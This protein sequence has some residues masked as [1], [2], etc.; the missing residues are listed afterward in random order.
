MA[1]RFPP[2]TDADIQGAVIKALQRAGWDVVRAID[3]FPEGT[4]DLP[5]FERALK[6]GRVLVT[7]DDDQK[8]IAI[9]WYIEGRPFVGVVWWP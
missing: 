7:N 9:R 2:Y 1:G 8:Q 3:A 5:H 4:K 6:L